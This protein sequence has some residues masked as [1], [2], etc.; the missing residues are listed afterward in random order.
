MYRK[1]SYDSLWGFCVKIF[2]SYGFPA[3]KSVQITDVLLT[4]DLFGTESHGISRM[5]K[6][7]TLIRRGIVSVSA[8][9]EAVYETPVSAVYDARHAMGQIAGTTGMRR[10]VEL[11]SGKGVGLVEVR[12]SNHYGIAGYYAL[13]AA[14]E[15]FAGISMTNTVPIMVPTFAAQPLL[16]SDPIAF[17]IP[18]ERE[19]FLFDSSTT[20]ITRGKLEVYGKRK[21]PLLNGWAVGND[22]AECLDAALVLNDIREQKGGGVLPIGGEGEEHAGYKGYGF[23]MICEIMTGIFSGGVTSLHKNDRGDT[24]HCFYALDPGIFGDPKEISHRLQTLLDEIRSSRKKRG[25]SRIFTHGEKEFESCFKKRNKGIPVNEETLREIKIIAKEQGVS[26]DG[27]E[28]L[29]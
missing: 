23:G 2:E 5:I 24:S 20:V 21:E 10:A 19:I 14:K 27:L 17:A 25:E 7:H 11:A 15:G 16:G 28:Y 3:S 26:A 8:Q 1:I 13:M 9:P 12:N 6:Y 18:A 4:A 22:G 29:G